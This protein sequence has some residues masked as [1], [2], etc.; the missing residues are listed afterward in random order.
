MSNAFTQSP[1]WGGLFRDAVVEQ[2]FSGPRMLERV[3]AFE[4]AW[5]Q[6]LAAAGLV[7]KAEADAALAAI[8]GFK[9]DWAALGAGSDQ[10]GLAIPELL[11]QLGA[12]LE[13]AVAQALHNGATSQDVIDTAFVLACRDILLDFE[14]RLDGILGQIAQLRA[15]F[16]TAQMMGRTRMQ[17]ARPIIVD[18]RCAAWHRPLQAIRAE[19]GALIGA[20]SVVQAG[21]PVGTRNPP[22]GKRDQVAA[23]V[24]A[25]LG[26]AQAAVWQT[27]R[28]VIVDAGHWLAKLTGSLGK[29]GADIGLM[30]QQGIDE[31]ALSGA[32]RSSSMAHKSNPVRAELLV[33]LA[34]FVGGQQG[35]LTGAMVHEQERSGAAWAL[36]WL[37]L[38]T[39][40]QAAGAALT[41]ADN[42]LLQVQ[43]IGDVGARS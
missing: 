40:F 3:L 38:P 7:D 21:G 4:R 15:Q 33:A 39:M 42:L 32:G 8:D 1:L 43:R 2:A 17:A 35:V 41:Q 10:D 9:P 14:V 29:L 30:A 36:E 22:N 13:P 37:V 27:D 20:L 23:F 18:D 5:T 12:G 16:G 26:L 31:I 34:R 11:R 19:T 6:G 24:A 28:R 25:N